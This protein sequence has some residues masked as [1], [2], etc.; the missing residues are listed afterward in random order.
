MSRLAFSTEESDSTT[1]IDIITQA[2]LL[3]ASRNNLHAEV[4]EELSEA[5][6]R[7]SALETECLALVELL[8]CETWTHHIPEVKQRLI[9]MLYTHFQSPSEVLARK[10]KKKKKSS[11]PMMAALVAE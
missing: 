7:Y 2:D 3:I 1:V 10:K 8:Q 6:K 11:G 4:V 9:A 5:S